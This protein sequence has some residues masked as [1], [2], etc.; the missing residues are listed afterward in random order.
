MKFLLIMLAIRL[1]FGLLD[2]IRRKDPVKSITDEWTGLA[3]HPA[4][5]QIREDGYRIE[6]WW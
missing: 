2:R 4:E 1:V 6:W 3:R 5:F